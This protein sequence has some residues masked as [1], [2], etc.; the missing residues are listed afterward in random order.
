MTIDDLLAT[1]R[2]VWSPKRVSVIRRRPDGGADVHTLPLPFGQREPASDCRD[3]WLA[4]HG[5]DVNG[6]V[7]CHDDCRGL[8]EGRP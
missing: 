5:L 1:A 6:R 4:V 8:Q 2:K 7:D 3:R